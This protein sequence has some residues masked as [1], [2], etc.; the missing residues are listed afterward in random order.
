MVLNSR[1][2]TF[3]LALMIGMVFIVLA[4]A[5]APAIKNFVDDA[6]APSSDTA[7][8]LDCSNASISKF[9]KAGC[10]LVDMFNPYFVGFLVFSAGVILTAKLTGVMQ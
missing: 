2:Q 3:L 7:V 6:R 9:D 1:G 10:L 4:L 8:G 5:F